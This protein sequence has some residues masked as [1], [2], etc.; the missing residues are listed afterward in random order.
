MNNKFCGKKSDFALMREDA[1]RV[2]IGYGL[3][4]VTGKNLYEWYEVYF[5]ATQ[6]S[7][8][9]LA[10]VKN[11]IIGDINAR[12]TE[13]ITLGFP[14]TVLHGAQAGTQVNVWL[15]KENQS[16]FHAM[17][18]NADALTFPVKYKVGELADG[19]AVYE[20]FANADEMHAICT[21][22]T[23]HILTCQQAGWAEKDGIDWAPYEA[24]FPQQEQ[25]QAPAEQE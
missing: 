19:T 3:K 8:V 24:L 22:T 11:A 9:N 21:A 16:D 25:E 7:Q 18:Q 1:S 12:T 23:S 14:Y 6:K 2:I 15:S 10:D 17:H 20:E 5:Y 13:A 4:K